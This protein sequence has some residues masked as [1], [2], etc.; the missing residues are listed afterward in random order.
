MSEDFKAYMDK[1]KLTNDQKNE[2]LDLYN[3]GRAS[4]GDI[5]RIL[6]RGSDSF[7]APSVR[8]K[9]MEFINKQ[10]EKPLEVIVSEPQ[11]KK[12][13]DKS[14]SVGDYFGLVGTYINIELFKS[15]IQD[16]TNKY[17]DRSKEFDI[18]ELNAD[19][20]RLN[21][22]IATLKEE[23]S[24]QF[25]KDKDF[26]GLINLISDFKSLTIA[27]NKILYH[28]NKFND[29]CD[30]DHLMALELHPDLFNNYKQSLETYILSME[31]AKTPPYGTPAYMS[32]TNALFKVKSQLDNLKS[33]E[34]L[35]QLNDRKK[36][37]DKC[38]DPVLR[39]KLLNELDRNT[40]EAILKQLGNMKKRT[41]DIIDLFDE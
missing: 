34:M 29:A 27:F 14:L 20:N 30:K 38:D 36:E 4:I 13:S 31:H 17:L 5:S 25:N 3:K 18:E 1:L 23:K 12:A 26:E 41:S 2:L 22:I 16:M 7:I 10:V 15:E 37:I 6:N 11:E 33:L 19:E 8:N 24:E 35:K 9:F 40:K 39:R 21:E 32:Y 28:Q